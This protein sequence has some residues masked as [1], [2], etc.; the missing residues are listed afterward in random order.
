LLKLR[1]IWRVEGLDNKLL[2][3]GCWLEQ[4]TATPTSQKRDVGHPAMF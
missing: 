3:A 1:E 2:V 4:T